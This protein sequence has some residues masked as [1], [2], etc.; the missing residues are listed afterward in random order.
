[1]Q[2]SLKVLFVEDSEIDAELTT[3]E[4]KRGGFIPTVQRVETRD[5]ME[6]SLQE[7]DWDL[8]ICDYLMPRFSAEAALNTLKASGKDLPFI[9]ASGAVTA[10]DAVNLLRKGAHDFMD[11]GALARLV[12]AIERELREADVRE[13]RR[14]A[15]AQINVLSQALEQCPVSV[16]I[17]NPDG[18]IEYANP[19]FEQVSGYSAAEAKGRELGFTLKQDDH[20]HLM[21]Q[22]SQLVSEG[23]RWG[24]EMPSIRSDG[25]MFWENVKASP[26]MSGDNNVSHYIVIK[27]DITVRRNYEQQ[28]L[29]QAHYDHLTGLANRVL[30]VEKLT[31]AMQNAGQNQHRLAVLGIDLDDFKNVNDSVGHTNGD[32]LLKEAAQRLRSCIRSGDTIARMGGDEF[33]VVLPYI[34]DANNASLMAQRIVKEFSKPFD[35]AGRQYSVTCSIGISLYPDNASNAHLMLRNA[36]LAMYQS[37]SQGRDQFQFFTEDINRRLVERLELE[38]KLRTVVDGNELVLHYQPIL[39][40]NTRKISGFEALVRW[41]QPDGSLKMPDSFIPAA[42]NIGAIQQIDS[43]VLATA[44]RETAAM[45]KHSGTDL[46]LA[47]NI[48]PLQLEDKGYVDFVMGQLDANGLQPHHLELE[49]TERV[50]VSDAETTET[51]MRALAELGI[52]MSV[53]DFGTGYSSL[54]YLKRYPLHTLKIDRSF[55]AD[56]DVDESARRLVETILLMAHGLKMGVVAE[57]VETEEQRELLHQMGCGQAQGYLLS[58]PISL[59]KIIGLIKLQNMPAQAALRLIK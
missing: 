17:T 40:L 55:V 57:G 49:I 29:R 50:L 54:G 38:T 45:L 33:V 7:N 24:G 47:I 10:E 44:C 5:D 46:H 52:R 26:L 16:L 32:E 22:L 43:W 19:Y 51:N 48:S 1:M 37:K 3:A 20:H 8:I 28:L 27:E 13:K 12:P 56:M 35:I 25:E 42:E 36:D 21:T 14:Q 41:Q 2:K 6:K 15:E 39:D 58:R 23:Q 59:E 31:Q 4:L 18:E 34:A 9:I 30:L 11:K 53:D